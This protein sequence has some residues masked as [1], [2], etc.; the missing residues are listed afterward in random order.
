MLVLQDL[1]YIESIVTDIS[2]SMTGH[3]GLGA[4]FMA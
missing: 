4:Y 1:D 3:P 2:E